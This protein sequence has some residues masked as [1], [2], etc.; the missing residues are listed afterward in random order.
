M[1]MVLRKITTKTALI[2]ANSSRLT[3]YGLKRTNKYIWIFK[4]AQ[5]VIDLTSSL[6]HIQ[7]PQN[8]GLKVLKLKINKIR[9]YHVEGGI[10]PDKSSE[11]CSEK[12]S[13]F[14]VSQQILEKG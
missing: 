13:V 9:G 14:L 8:K 1:E 5:N 11:M 6:K 10:V 4:Y 3:E 7:F 2:L 12:N